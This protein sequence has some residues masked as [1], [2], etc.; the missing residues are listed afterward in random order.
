MFI[1]LGAKRLFF[2]PD[3]DGVFTLF[4]IEYFL[5]GMLLMGLGIVGE[6][7][8]RIYE[9]VRKRPRFIIK[10]Y[11]DTQQKKDDKSCQ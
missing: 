7:I 3:A 8:G 1:Y 11:L 4:A 5:L 10:E 2:A 9:E 6:Y